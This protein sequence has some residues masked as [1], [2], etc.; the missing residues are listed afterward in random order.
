[1]DRPSPSASRSLYDPT[2]TLLVYFD[3]WNT[4]CYASMCITIIQKP[5][6]KFDSDTVL[7]LNIKT[8]NDSNFLVCSTAPLPRVKMVNK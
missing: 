1:M 2:H 3:V 8:E 4:V 5:N 6:Q 7:S